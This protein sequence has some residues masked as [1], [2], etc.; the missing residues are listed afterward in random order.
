[1]DTDKD[2]AGMRLAAFSERVVAFAI[3]MGL[4]VS[5]HFATL[6]LASPGWPVLL[7]PRANLWMAL[8]ILLFILYQAYCS[9]EGR[10]SLGKWL[11]GLRVVDLENE[12]LS[13][14][15]AAL[16]SF[17][18]PVSSLLG[19]G[20]LWALFNKSRQ[21][22]HDLATGSIVVSGGAR[23]G[24]ALAVVRLGAG[25]VLA[26]LG[27]LWYW[28]NVISDRY[29]NIMNI[30]YAQ[31]GLREI[32]T[33]QK[34]YHKKHGRYARTLLALSSASSAPRRFYRDMAMLYDVEQ[35]VKIETSKQ[36]FSIRAHAMDDERTLVALNGP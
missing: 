17:L 31:V 26:M 33:L 18:Y 27:A 8:W 2:D 32:S 19:L 4:F 21:C 9:C 12:P 20:F 34:A 13:L 29:Y 10:V 6:A 3:D 7:S 24:V 25:L 28:Q 1:M 36:G 35:G 30:A 16:R 11:L 15:P 23:A 5:A 14:G 22:W